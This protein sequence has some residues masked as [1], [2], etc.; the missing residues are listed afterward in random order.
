MLPTTMLGGL[1]RQDLAT[2]GYILTRAISKKVREA[3]VGARQKPGKGRRQKILKFHVFTSKIK[4]VLKKRV[5][6]GK[7][8]YRYLGTFVPVPKLLISHSV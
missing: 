5:L 4:N 6:V 8:H 1:P 2:D 3:K 7:V